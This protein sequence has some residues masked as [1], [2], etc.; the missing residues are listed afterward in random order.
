MTSRSARTASTEPKLSSQ[1]ASLKL[2]DV[3]FGYDGE[4]VAMW[5]ADFADFGAVDDK[6]NKQG[7]H[8]SSHQSP[9]APIRTRC[10]NKVDHSALTALCKRIRPLA[11][12]SGPLEGDAQG[13]QPRTASNSTLASM[14]LK[15]SLFALPASLGLFFGLFFGL[16]YPGEP[17]RRLSVV[18]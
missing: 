2:W 17:Q 11:Q 4:N 9:S 12:G 5:R 14:N 10:T 15:W 13:P 6:V 18:W 16:S 3:L 8:F 1:S 7:V